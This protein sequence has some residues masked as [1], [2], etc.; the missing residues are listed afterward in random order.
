MNFL[1]LFQVGTSCLVSH[2]KKVYSI[3]QCVR[4]GSV[5]L[6]TA[7]EYIKCYNE[8]MIS[9]VRKYSSGSSALRRE[10]TVSH[11]N[12]YNYCRDE[13][14]QIEWYL[15]GFVDTCSQHAAQQFTFCF[16]KF[17]RN[18]ISESSSSKL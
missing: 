15:R 8:L 5:T 13:E 12:E 7:I 3:V 2:C 14:P 1:L 6:Y 11:E 18:K 9:E 17:I 16:F 4:M 10:A